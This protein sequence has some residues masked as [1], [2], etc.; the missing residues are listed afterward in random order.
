MWILF[1]RMVQVKWSS[2]FEFSPARSESNLN[3]VRGW[4]EGKKVT[5]QPDECSFRF[6]C[7]VRFTCMGDQASAF[8]QPWCSSEHGSVIFEQ[9]FLCVG[10]W[11]YTWMAFSLCRRVSDVICPDQTSVCPDGQTCC[12]L[13]S[14]EWGCC[15]LPQVWLHVSR[16]KKSVITRNTSASHIVYRWMNKWNYSWILPKYYLSVFFVFF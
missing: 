13:G 16:K 6:T 2:S 11:A 3:W 10:E 4:W 1:S 14:G 8:P 12:E 9:H 5:Y 7:P 15:P